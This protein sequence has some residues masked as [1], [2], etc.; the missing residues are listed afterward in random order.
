MKKQG[1]LQKKLYFCPMSFVAISAPMTTKEH[2]PMPEITM[3]KK[4][5][6]YVLSACLGIVSSNAGATLLHDGATLA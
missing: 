5:F 4:C 2:L 6:L 3:N 1:Y